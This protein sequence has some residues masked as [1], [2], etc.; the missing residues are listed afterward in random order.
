MIGLRY[1]QTKAQYF[2]FERSIGLRIFSKVQFLQ[3][4]NTQASTQSV[5][6]RI[7]TGGAAEQAATQGTEKL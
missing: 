1:F 4:Y 3:G 2:I 6:A 7:A 5:T